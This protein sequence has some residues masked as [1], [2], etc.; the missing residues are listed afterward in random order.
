MP[1]SAQRN[2]ARTTKP[3]MN[4]TAPIARPLFTWNSKGVMLQAGAGLAGFLQVPL[5]G[6]EF[7]APR[8]PAARPLRWAALASVAGL[9]LWRG[10][11]IRPRG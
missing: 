5:V 8:W 9:L 10:R 2:S 4:L 11:S 1:G 3:W 7:T 6:A